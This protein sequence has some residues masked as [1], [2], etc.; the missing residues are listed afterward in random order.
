MSVR[1]LRDMAND[2]ANTAEHG[3]CFYDK[4]SMDELL[5]AFEA[6]K[7]ECLAHKAQ[8]DEEVTE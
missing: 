4:K 8:I 7:N 3:E 2:I 5:S 6:F 1:Y